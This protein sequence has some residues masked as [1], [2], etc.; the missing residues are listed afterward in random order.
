MKKVLISVVAMVAFAM[1]SNA[2]LWLG[3]SVSASHRGGVEKN[4]V[5][6]ADPS[7]TTDLDNPKSNDFSI[8]PKIGFG[9]NEKLSV[10]A[11]LNFATSTTGKVD[12]DNLSKDNSFG[13]T[14]FVRYTFVE[15]GKFGV[16]A[17]AGLPILFT[18]GKTVLG[19]TE[20]KN[21]P[22]SMFGLSVTPWLTY[23]ATDHFSLECGLNF[24]GLSAFHTVTKDQNDKDHKWVNNRMGCNANTANL[25]TVGGI[26]IGFIYKL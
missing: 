23:N 2:Q 26:T 19:G 13:V 5:D 25:A 4:A 11:E 21:N 3:G 22:S 1:T 7:K 17:E 16:L 14:P 12:K 8:A 10:G 15:F 6:P 9:L 18:S 24:L 20:T